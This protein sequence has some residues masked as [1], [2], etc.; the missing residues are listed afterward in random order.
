M[1]KHV[2]SR[3]TLVVCFILIVTL[4]VTLLLTWTPVRPPRG[5]EGQLESQTALTRSDLELP[6]LFMKSASSQVS[7]A[8]AFQ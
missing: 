2:L 5:Q 7:G 1:K 8:A 6:S 4:L 3:L